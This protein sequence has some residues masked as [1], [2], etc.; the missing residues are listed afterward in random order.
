MIIWKYF[1]LIIIIFINLLSLIFT[2]I[3]AK[4][5][6]SSWWRL[7]TGRFLKAALSSLRIGDGATGRTVSV[8]YHH[9]HHDTNYD[10][11]D[12]DDDDTKNNH[13]DEDS[14]EEDVNLLYE[15]SFVSFFYTNIF[16]Q[17]FVSIFFTNATLGNSKSY[18]DQI[19]ISLQT[20][21]KIE[22]T[23]VKSL[24]CVDL[25][26][27]LQHQHRPSRFGSWTISS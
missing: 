24:L 6:W 14:E 3:F 18:Y 2:F 5:I 13:H 1:L 25:K 21:V 20:K 27:C 19:N 16:K 8:R 17:S 9:Y 10:D 11:N 23:L 4:E 26:I 15:Y 7:T 22:I 12:D